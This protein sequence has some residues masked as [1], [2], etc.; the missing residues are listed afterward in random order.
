MIGYRGGKEV[1]RKK[2]RTASAPAKISLEA[3]RTTIAADGYDLSFITV[4][5][6][7]KNGAMCPRADN[8]IDFEIVGKG[9]IAAVDN[10]NSSTT[11][12]F[13]ANWRRAFNGM[14]LVIVR[15]EPGEAGKI[16]LKASS[17]GLKDARVA[18]TAK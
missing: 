11:D 14:A 3:D 1:A 18:I 13:Q 9:E 5:V 17:K 16:T 15:S 6:E 2:I 4:R 7:D 8:K 10:G 12:P